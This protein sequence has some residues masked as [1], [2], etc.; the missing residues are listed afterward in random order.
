MMKRK[1]R[2]LRLGVCMAL[3]LCLMLGVVGCG[4]DTPVE[5]ENKEV[6]LTEDVQYEI[7]SF[8]SVFPDNRL[9]GYDQKKTI[10]FEKIRFA[11]SFVEKNDFSSVEY[12]DEDEKFYTAINLDVL[13]TALYHYFGEE[14]LLRE[15][16][17]L[18]SEDGDEEFIF[19]DGQVLHPSADSDLS[20]WAVIVD[21]MVEG[22]DGQFEVDFHVYG[23]DN[24]D[25]LEFGEWDDI[26]HYN[27]EQAK[28]DKHIELQADGKAIVKMIH[29]EE[30]DHYQLVMLTMNMG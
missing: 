21:K 22:E 29:E 10:D 8:L 15:N 12:L 5:E 19:R 2:V 13:N 18:T 7:N 17:I 3:L 25:S 20:E 14:I 24:L 1:K 28:E 23:V 11:H 9:F 26:L 27:A 16:E 4:D 30:E 6:E